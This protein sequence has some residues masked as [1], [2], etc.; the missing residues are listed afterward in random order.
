MG[1]VR[2]PPERHVAW[3]HRGISCIVTTA[4]APKYVIEVIIDEVPVWSQTFDS[5][6][7]VARETERLWKLFVEQPT[8]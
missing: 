7:E 3:A 4:A 5:P 6:Q 8:P 2:I 1:N